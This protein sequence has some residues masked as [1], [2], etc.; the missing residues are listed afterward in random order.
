MRHAPL[1][2][3]SDRLDR[4]IYLVLEDFGARA[5]CSWRE[6]DEQGS[7]RETVIRDLLS[8]QYAYR[9]GS[10]PSTPS[11]AGWGTPPQ[12]LPMSWRNVQSIQMRRSPRRWKHSSRPMRHGVSS[13]NYLS[14][15]PVQHHS[16]FQ[17]ASFGC[18]GFS[19]LLCLLPPGTTFD[20]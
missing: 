6:T 12:R 10:S 19:F 16:R 18:T 4:D 2:V 8:G 17:K 20:C 9:L 3:P 15:Y 5:G 7:D 11:K 1:I 13:S 14:P